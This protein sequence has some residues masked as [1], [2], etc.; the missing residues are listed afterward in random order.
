MTSNQKNKTI[1][2]SKR[3]Q[4]EQGNWL[5]DLNC[6]AKKS[7]MKNL[8]GKHHFKKRA[9]R[10][11]AYRILQRIGNKYELFQRYSE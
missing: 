6:L 9:I 3:K 1:M 10:N 4:S 5:P 7:V 2:K 8:R 11:Q